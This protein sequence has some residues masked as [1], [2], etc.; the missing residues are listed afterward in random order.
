MDGVSAMRRAGVL[1]YIAAQEIAAGEVDN[2]G[3]LQPLYL[4]GP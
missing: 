3:T 4:Q 2:L 1:A